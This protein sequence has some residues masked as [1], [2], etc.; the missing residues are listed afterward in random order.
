VQ[1]LAIVNPWS[2]AGRSP[3]R[4]RAALD[5]VARVTDRTI[6]T[7][8]AGHARELAASAERFDGLIVMGGDGTL[9]EVLNGMDVERQQLT[10]LPTGRGN[11]LARDLGLY[12]LTT[13]LAALHA[14]R[15]HRID[16]MDATFEDRAGHQRHVLSASTIGLGYPATVVRLAAKRFRAFGTYCYAAAAIGARP[17]R[18]RMRLSHDAGPFLEDDLT[19]FVANNTRHLAN[20]VGLPDASPYDGAFDVMEM[21]VGA[22]RQNLHNLSA[23]SQLHCYAPVTVRRATSVSVELDRPQDLMVDGELFSEIITL[24]IGIRPHAV[25]FACAEVPV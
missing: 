3:E 12:P 2:S 11:S 4:I 17:V 13:S 16:L 7:E 20:F 24:R 21:R 10:L 9:N 1:Q 15:R 8:H 23:L 25:Q 18:A 5:R 14:D 19:G 6:V 22:F